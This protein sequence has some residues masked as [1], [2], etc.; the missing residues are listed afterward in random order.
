MNDEQL[1]RTRYQ[2]FALRDQWTYRFLRWR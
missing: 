1:E 2:S